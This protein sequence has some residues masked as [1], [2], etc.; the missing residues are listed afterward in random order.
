MKQNATYPLRLPISLK[1][2][3]NK[4]AA[5]DRPNV[6]EAARSQ[7]HFDSIRST[8]EFKDFMKQ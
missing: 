7:S 5:L 1:E 8:P 2:E 3:V 6:K 4:A